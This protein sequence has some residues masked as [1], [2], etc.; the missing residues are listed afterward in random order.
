[1]LS[2]LGAARAAV[3]P[4]LGPVRPHLPYSAAKAVTSYPLGCISPVHVEIPA[5]AEPL[6]WLCPACSDRIRRHLFTLAGCWGL[7]EALLQR[8]PG[9]QGEGGGGNKVDAAAPLD[10][11]VAEIR[12]A[13]AAWCWSLVEHMLEDNRRLSM[14]GN[15]DTAAILEWVGRWHVG[16]ITGHPDSSFPIAMQDELADM[17]RR[18]RARLLP[19]TVRR[20]PLPAVC[21]VI[22]PAAADYA[23]C[24]GQLV[25]LIRE[26]GGPATITCREDPSH[27]IPQTE[28]LH[29]FK[30]KGRK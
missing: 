30:T 22:L 27:E 8:G 15:T 24:G 23:K 26:D 18:V 5:L 9:R 4:A 3:I 14:P 21:S 25:A 29:M 28:W 17:V 13:I 16:Y 19:E 7:L 2:G 11:E 1:M 10:L 6:A 12:R 20:R